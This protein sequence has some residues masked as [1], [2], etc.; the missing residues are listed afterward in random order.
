MCPAE[1]GQGDCLLVLAPRLEGVLLQSGFHIFVLFLAFRCLK[2]TPKLSAEVLSGVPKLQK[3]A[4]CLP[5]K[6]HVG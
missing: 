5:E 4:M 3:A 1:V 6:R 2:K